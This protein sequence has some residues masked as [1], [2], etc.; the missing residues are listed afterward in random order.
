MGKAVC[1]WKCV[2]CGTMHHFQLRPTTCKECGVKVFDPIEVRFESDVSGASCGVD[3]LVNLGGQKLVP[4]ELKTMDKE[5]FKA[6]KAPIAEHKWR[7]THYLRI[8]DESA[9]SWS[10]LVDTTAGRIL[11]VSKGGYGCAD[12]EPAK[13]GMTDKYS[14][15]KEFT[16]KRD[17]PLT[18]D[19]HIRAKTVTDFRKGL[20]G[21]PCGICPTAMAKRASQCPMRVACFSGDHPPKFD[22]TEK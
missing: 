11:Y 18:E 10:N 17:D 12:E 14:P 4:V 9:K 20:V 6:L 16:I 19:L 15:F 21:M 2:A 5:Q 13:W 8:I 7:T 22:W 3:M 1:H